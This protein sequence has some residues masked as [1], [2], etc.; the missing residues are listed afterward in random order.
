MKKLKLT[1]AQQKAWEIGWVAFSRLDRPN[2]RKKHGKLPGDRGYKSKKFVSPFLF[3]KET[4]NE[5][6]D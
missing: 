5:E 3:E 1:T 2:L 6:K 4:L